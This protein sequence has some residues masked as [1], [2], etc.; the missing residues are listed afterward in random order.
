MTRLAALLMMGALAASCGPGS[1]N[2]NP[3]ELWL[4]LGSDELHAQLI[5]AQPP[6]Y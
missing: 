3:P 5:A 6:H 1:T 2:D 4:A